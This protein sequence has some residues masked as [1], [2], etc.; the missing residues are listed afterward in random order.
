MTPTFC[1]SIDSIQL[2]DGEELFEKSFYFTDLFL[3]YIFLMFIFCFGILTLYLKAFGFHIV[4]WDYFECHTPVSSATF[5]W[6][7][8]YKILQKDISVKVDGSPRL[9]SR[10]HTPQLFFRV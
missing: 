1:V 6:V 5:L 4:A 7:Y 8:R 9:Y 3:Q 10:P 2:T